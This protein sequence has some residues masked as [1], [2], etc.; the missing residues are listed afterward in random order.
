MEEYLK[1]LLEQI[2]CKKV[3]PYIRQELQSHMEDQIQ[4]YVRAGMDYENAEKE[5]V[6]D[7]GDPVETG[8]SL[9]RVHKPSVAWRLLLMIVLISAAGMIM[10]MM[11]S[12]NS[13]GGEAYIS[14]RYV[15]H[16]IAGIAV[17]TGIYFIDYTVVAR[18]SKWIAGA[19]LVIGMLNLLM[20][21]GVN[22]MTYYIFAGR[23]LI[24]MQALLL[25]YVPVYGGI[26]YQYRGSGY[27]GLIKAVVWMIV[28]VFLAFVMPAIMAA[29]LL[30]VSMLVMLSIAV[31]K[32]WFVIAKKRAL[33]GLWGSLTVL[34]VAALWGM[35]FG[36]ILK[37]Y[38]KARIQAFVSG[39]GEESYLTVTLRSFLTQN[40]LVGHNGTDVSEVLPGFN[41]DYILTYL[42]S[43]YGMIAAILACCVLVVLIAIV[44]GAVL[45]QKN[46]LGLVMGCGCGMVLLGSLLINIL[47][48]LGA[49]PPTATFL[50][51]L[52]G[53][54]S[55][56]IVS[57]GLIGIV[58]SIYRYKNIYPRHVKVGMPRIKINI[59]L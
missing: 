30:L 27:K 3:R 26:V 50:P 21:G 31:W 15:V 11:I 17:M 25:F 28:P 36:N 23:G 14:G 51:F 56:L 53:G 20:G 55:Y 42:S 33:A 45:K 52:S 35:Y 7:M 57:Y 38:Q 24:S 18:F 1:I 47:E 13:D 12:Q 10:H 59:E 5:A 46:Q 4:A 8:V 2:R 16:A 22:G 6:R 19:I 48:N 9:D 39:S 41:T 54:G 44:F 58:L 32:D 37:E 29:G 43:T 40:K 34:P 49:L